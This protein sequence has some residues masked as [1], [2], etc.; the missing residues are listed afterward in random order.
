MHGTW[1]NEV[2][3]LF[4]PWCLMTVAGLAPITKVFSGN[5]RSG[6]ADDVSVFGFFGGATRLTSLSFARLARMLPASLPTDLAQRRKMWFERMEVL[7]S[8]ILCSAFIVCFAQTV[9]GTIDWRE[10]NL[11]RAIEPVLFL[12]VII[13]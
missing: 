12:I 5:G 9:F 11:G 1:T 2:R 3:L 4:W 10:F 6:W 7:A 13:C 8:A